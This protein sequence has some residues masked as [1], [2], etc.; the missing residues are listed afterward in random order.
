MPEAIITRVFMRFVMRH[1]YDLFMGGAIGFEPT[2]VKGVLRSA[3]RHIE[4]GMTGDLMLQVNQGQVHGMCPVFFSSKERLI[5][6]FKRHAC[7]LVERTGPT[8]NETLLIRRQ[9]NELWFAFS[10]RA[11]VKIMER[12]VNAEQINQ[13]SVRVSFVCYT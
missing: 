3:M 1:V 7:L 6:F 9:I 8:C 10:R 11:A 2:L 12:F 4:Q 13:T 5:D